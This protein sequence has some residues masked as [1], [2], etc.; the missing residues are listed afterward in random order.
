MPFLVDDVV[1]NSEGF[2]QLSKLVQ[3]P[4]VKH[5]EFTEASD[6]DPPH[7]GLH[8]ADGAKTHLCVVYLSDMD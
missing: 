2:K 3:K 6:S 5:G 7:A 8:L 1:V 4:P